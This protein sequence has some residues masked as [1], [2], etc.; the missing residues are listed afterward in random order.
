MAL[1]TASIFLFSIRRY[2][3]H[4][5]TIHTRLSRG[6][7]QLRFFDPDHRTCVSL[8]DEQDFDRRKLQH[9]FATACM[10]GAKEREYY[11]QA[12]VTTDVELEPDKYNINKILQ[13]LSL[14]AKKTNR[15]IRINMKL[16]RGYNNEHRQP[17]SL[18]NV[19]V[20]DTYGVHVVEP[21]YWMRAKVAQKLMGVRDLVIQELT[22]DEAI[23][24]NTTGADEIVIRVDELLALDSNMIGELV[25][26]D[27]GYTD[28]KWVQPFACMREHPHPIAIAPK[29]DPLNPP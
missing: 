16:Q 12:T 11:L 24:T 6:S 18:V 19:V 29:N 9:H 22:W 15:A 8:K 26:P 27:G 14:V 28:G 23:V 3:P 5:F 17:Y 2:D 4:I 25:G 10:F 21:G 20:L 1:T 7:R 13:A